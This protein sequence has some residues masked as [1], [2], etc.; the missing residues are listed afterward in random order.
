MKTRMFL[1]LLIAALTLSPMAYAVD[2]CQYTA[3]AP[4]NAAGGN[5]AP[6]SMSCSGTGLRVDASG[7]SAPLPAGAATSANQTNVQSAPGA[8]AGTAIGVQGVSGGVPVPISGSVTGSISPPAVATTTLLNAATTTG[9]GSSFSIPNGGRA[10]FEAIGN[11]SVTSATIN[12]EVSNVFGCASGFVVW[13]TITL[14]GASDSYGTSFTAPW[15]CVRGNVTA[16]SGASA[17][18]TLYMGS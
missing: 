7:S 8:S 6:V 3:A 11:A 13:Q 5:N 17:N 18:V 1:G 4:N 12:I 15:L 14:T 16:I 2:T 10:S 9:A